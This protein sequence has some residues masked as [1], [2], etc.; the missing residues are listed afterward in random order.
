MKGFKYFF[1]AFVIIAS[2]ATYITLRAPIFGNPTFYLGTDRSFGAGEN[3][4]VNLEGNG[5][6]SYEF[7]V[8]KIADPKTFLTKKVKERLV[9]EDNENAFGNPLAL[10]SRTLRKFQNEFRSVARREFNSNT[11]SEL[12]KV[13]GV[14]YEAAYEQKPIAVPAILS[15]QELISSFSVPTVPSSWAYRRIP[16]PVRDNGVYLVEGVSGSNLAY[17]ILIKSGINFL[18]KQSDSETLLF[19]GRKDTGEPIP[20]ADLTLFSLETGTPYQTAKT[21]SDGIYFYKGKSPVKSLVLAYR[22]GEFAVSDPEF[23]SSSFYGEGGARAFLYTDRPVYRPGDKVSFK[24]ILRNFTSDQYRT[25]SGTGTVSVRSGQG[26]VPVP[27]I[28]VSISADSGTFSGEFQLPESENVF[29]GNYSLILRFKEKSFQTEFS[30]EAYKKP[31]FLVTVAVPKSNYLQ[32]EEIVANVKARYYYGQALTGKDVSYRVFRR[33]KFDYSPVGKLNFDASADYLEQAGQSDRQELVLNGKGKLDSQGGYQITF[34]PGKI[35][36]DFTY[37]IIASVQSED[38]TLDGAT[39]FSVNRSAFFLRI[40]KDNSVYEP[41]KEAKLLVSLIPFD[42]SLADENKKSV[43][44]GKKIELTLYNREI[45]F[46]AEGGRTKISKRS[47]TTSQLGIAETTFVIPQRGQYIV[48]AESTDID[49][50]ITK[51]ETFFWASSVSDSIEI[52]FKDITLKPGKDLYSTG[53]TAE[54]LVL[55]PISNGHIVL[56]VEGNRIFKKDVIRM[57]GNAL[58]YSVKITSDMSPNFTL[59]AVQFSGND[60]YKSQV[61]VAAPPEEKFLKVELSTGSKVY[62]PGDKAEIRIKTTALGGRGVPAELSIAVVDEAIYQIK[63]EKTPNIGTFF[64]HPRR[65]NVQTSLASSYKFFGYSENKRL[66]LALGKKGESGYSSIKNEEQVRDKFKDTGFWNAK[67]RTASDGTAIVTFVL[68]DNLT[69]WRITAIAVTPDTK[70]GRGQTGFVTRKDLMLLSGMPRYILKGETQKVSATVSN[71]SGKKLPIKVSVKTEG[72]KIIGSS[73]TDITLEPRQNRSVQFQLQALQDPKIKSAKIILTAVGGG[74]SDSLRSEIQLKTWGLRRTVSDSLGMSEGDGTGSLKVEAPK[75]LAD[76]R[77]EVRVSPAVL[78]ALRQSLEYLAD[79]PYGC[80]EQTM[81]RFYPLLSV[82][83]AGFI[84]ERLRRELPKMLEAGLKRVGE[85]QRTDGGFGWFE[86][87]E[88]SDIRMSAYVYRG[89]AI[90]QKNGTKIQ[91]SILYRAKNFLYAA[92]D[93]GSLNPNVKAYVIASL[94]ETGNLEDSIVDGLLKSAAQLNAYG[95]ANLALTLVNKGR[96]AEASNWY[97][98]AI[99]ESG[100]AKKP[101]VK[102]TS[103]GREPNWESDRIETIATLLRVGLLLGESSE[104]TANLASSLLS[105]R[106]DLAWNNSRDTSAAVLALSEFMASVRDSE[107]PATL[108]I[109]MNGASL[110]TFSVS[111]KADATEAFRIPIAPELVRSGENRIE[112]KKKDGPVLYATASLYFTDRSK[113]ISSYSNGIKVKR[114]YLKVT[115]DSGGKGIAVSDTRNFQPGDLVLVELKVEK[116]G[117]ADSYFLVEDVL[118]PG[119]SFLQRD[120]EYLSG[121]RKVEYQGRQI[122]DDRAVFFVA[123]PKREFTVRYFLRAEVEGKYKTI[124]ARAS[125]MYYPEVMGATSD[126]EIT[127]R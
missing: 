73:E 70:V 127:V 63:E 102:F 101:F 65:N 43:V 108:E 56:T 20:N 15:D 9:Q 38:M 14:D 8:Y 64:Y 120:A 19:V 54:I 105:N 45:R 86:G 94:S 5:R 124:P 27:A 21:D 106:I 114:N 78:P 125:L 89:L 16:V 11:R 110:K 121:D 17:T 18:V 60:V 68:P 67:V 13:F 100:F 6:I 113:K 122:Y 90:S 111:A 69:S 93:S 47:V 22:N 75:E 41:G 23:Y 79:Y 119:F 42:R 59:S 103:Y 77:L 97:K 104:S 25:L 85:L 88:E 46:S 37:S 72:A 92:L 52:P 12:K 76:P 10:F 81:S 95:K 50:N 117:N 109:I 7:R 40:G 99:E 30:V 29:L 126:D 49:G 123:G 96:K 61:R 98:K 87:M 48:A 62:R 118:L 53:E 31:T 107:S 71:Q 35:D 83:K 36:N 91:T 26:D 115:P 39:S 58:K 1:P 34:K 116:E 28:P 32:K 44:G 24:G 82:Q 4:Y 55:T 3:A 66:K 80:V 74:Y 84:N 51:S 112:I 33:P 57:K 2:V